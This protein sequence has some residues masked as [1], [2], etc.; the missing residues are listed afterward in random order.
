[1]N[2]GQD[3]F[4]ITIRQSRADVSHF[5]KEQFLKGVADL[6]KPHIDWF[7][8]QSLIQMFVI[9]ERVTDEMLALHG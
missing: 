8:L 4:Y 7:G 5:A 3:G 6:R 9:C 1:M 2:A